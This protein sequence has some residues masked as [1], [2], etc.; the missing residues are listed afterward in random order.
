MAEEVETMVAMEMMAM[1][2]VIIV[3]VVLLLVGGDDQGGDKSCVK[4]L[5][6]S[7]SLY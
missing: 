2:V 4:N 3:M 7:I 1:W 6:A 5:A